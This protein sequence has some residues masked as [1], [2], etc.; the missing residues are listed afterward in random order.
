MCIVDRTHSRFS[1]RHDVSELRY[2]KQLAF[3][4][5]AEVLTGGTG[6]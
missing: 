6:E 3:C 2:G 1:Y 5:A 4:A